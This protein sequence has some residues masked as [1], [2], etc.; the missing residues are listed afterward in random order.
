MRCFSLQHSCAKKWMERALLRIDQGDEAKRICHIVQIFKASFSFSTKFHSVRSRSLSNSAGLLGLSAE[1]LTQP[2][3]W[4][5]GRRK[6]G[7]AKSMVLWHGTQSCQLQQVFPGWLGRWFVGPSNVMLPLG[8][9]VEGW[10]K[11]LYLVLSKLT[12]FS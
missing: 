3:P 9:Y 1:S 2:R 6:I 11:W 4:L 10:N 12:S 8:I 5:T 7:H